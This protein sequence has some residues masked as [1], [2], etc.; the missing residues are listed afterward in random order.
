MDIRIWYRL[1]HQS[2]MTADFVLWD[3]ILMMTPLSPTVSNATL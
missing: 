3:S 2:L 1:G